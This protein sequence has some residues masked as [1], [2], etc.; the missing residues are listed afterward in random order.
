MQK[1]G[2]G[3]KSALGNGREGCRGRAIFDG[4]DQGIR[5]V[6]TNEQRSSI[7]ENGDRRLENE[8]RVY[9]VEEARDEAL[10]REE[11]LWIPIDTIW[12]TTDEKESSVVWIRV[13]GASSE[14]GTAKVLQPSPLPSATITSDGSVVYHDEDLRG[15]IGELRDSRR[16]TD[17][18]V[19]RSE[20]W[21]GERVEISNVTHIYFTPEGR[22]Q[23]VEIADREM[24][25]EYRNQALFWRKQAEQLERRGER[26]RAETYRSCA[27]DLEDL[28]SIDR[29]FRR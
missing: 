21:E 24:L 22:R 9:T 4:L 20:E 25:A 18:D 1:K 11:D 13:L 29:R 15:V 17:E 28:F 27:D 7:M 16:E 12:E 14:K 5:S 3:F 2:D 6:I 8:G 10:R 19:I 26:E 23:M